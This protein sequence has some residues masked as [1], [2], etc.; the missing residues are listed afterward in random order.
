M[1]IEACRSTAPASPVGEYDEYKQQAERDGRHDEGVGGHDLV[2]MWVRNVRQV[3]E[4]EVWWR[5]MYLAT[6][7]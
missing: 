4:G 2:G 6:V 1:R 3:C 7:D 5:R